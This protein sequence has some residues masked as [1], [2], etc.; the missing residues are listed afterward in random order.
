[1]FENR[2]LRKTLGP[3]KDEVR[4]TW[5]M[6]HNEDLYNLNPSP[7]IIQVTKSIR[8]RL[9]WHVASM[10]DRK[11]AYRILVGRPDGKTLLGRPRRT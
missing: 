10:G 9:A 6:L 1:M 5:R 2:V 7:N 3:E 11:G 4:G 8:V